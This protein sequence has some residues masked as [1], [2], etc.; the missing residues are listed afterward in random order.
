[1]TDSNTSKCFSWYKTNFISKYQNFLQANLLKIKQY[2]KKIETKPQKVIF[3][4]FQK[5]ESIN[6]DKSVQNEIFS[7]VSL[8]NQRLYLKVHW[9]IQK[10]EH[11]TNAV[12]VW[13][14]KHFVAESKVEKTLLSVTCQKFSLLSGNLNVYKTYLCCA[15]KV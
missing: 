14:Q 4:R 15:N 8:L 7:K 13:K 12:I 10:S 2:G 6:L 1:M 9:S 5:F 3:Y 11:K